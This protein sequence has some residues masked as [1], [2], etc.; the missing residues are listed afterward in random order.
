MTMQITKD[1][2]EYLGEQ[3]LNGDGFIELEVSYPAIILLPDT[4]LCEGIYDHA[5]KRAG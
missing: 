2:K 3:D 5:Q 1:G 4:A